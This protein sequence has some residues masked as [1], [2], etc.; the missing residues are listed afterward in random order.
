MSDKLGYALDWK[1]NE[2]FICVTYI[3]FIMVLKF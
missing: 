3:Y 2:E 1:K